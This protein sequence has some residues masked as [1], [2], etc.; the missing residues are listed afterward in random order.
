MS[1]MQKELQMEREREAER[2]LEVW[3]GQNVETGEMTATRTNEMGS[4]T[5]RG[6]YTL[7]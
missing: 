7:F 2:R 6:N 5:K 1:K 4:Q 3:G